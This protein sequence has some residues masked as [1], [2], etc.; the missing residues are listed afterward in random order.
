MENLCRLVP[1]LTHIILADRLWIQR[2]PPKPP[3]K[4]HKRKAPKAEP[5]DRKNKVAKVSARSASPTKSV[6]NKQETPRRSGRE[7]GAR[8]SR[9]GVAR[10]LTPPP[11]LGRGTR[12][13]KTQ[14]NAKLD[15]QAKELAA[16]RKE[17]L[18]LSRRPAKP[19]SPK[20]SR[21]S[22]REAPA[23]SVGTRLSSRLRGK[24]ESEDEWQPVP[25]EWLAGGSGMMTDD[26]E[27]V[28]GTPRRSSTRLSSARTREYSRFSRIES[29][30][31]SD[32]TELTEAG[33]QDEDED[34]G[35]EAEAQR[36][37]EPEPEPE[38]EK[39]PEESL[40]A[41]NFIEWETVSASI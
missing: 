29:G 32:L 14:A 10:E 7:R 17:M 11:I 8:S 3:R 15:L 35:V 34:E 26:E 6:P 24:T 21:M 4:S 1:T 30:N 23:K 5:A 37:L 20:T 13:A 19:P 28:V 31:E 39:E 22:S 41:E 9:K 27:Y 36:E 18:S 38:S 25:D 40:V 33:E 12:A 2:T 16:T